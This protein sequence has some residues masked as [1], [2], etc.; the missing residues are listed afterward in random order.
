MGS[1]PTPGTKL[2]K[3]IMPW[4]IVALGYLLGCIP[5]AYI[6]GRL[7]KGRDI[8]QLG[9]GNMGAQNAFR[10]LG[11]KTGVVVG[12]VDAS[13]GAMAILI[14]QTTNT[15]Q[16]VI[17]LAGSAVVI[18]HNWPVFLGFK[19]GRGESATIGVLLVLITQPMLL[20]S[21]I[22]AAVL[23][24]TGNVIKASAVLFMPLA[25]VCWW[26]GVSGLLIAYSIG[27]PCLIG[28]TH[29]LRT[30]RNLIRSA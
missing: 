26:L 6:A 18:G 17:L 29:F 23:F 1:S 3:I 22:A 25:L 19:G 7:T 10:E 5:T 21:S 15:H 4:L 30:R 11:A 27:L 13:K 16:V 8:R 24:K 12:I 9:D 20:V 2:K 28:F 14:A